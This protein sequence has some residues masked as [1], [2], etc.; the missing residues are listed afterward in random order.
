MNGPDFD[1]HEL[2]PVIAQDD[3]SGDVLEDDWILAAALCAQLEEMEW[4]P[5]APP[6]IIPAPDPLKDMKGKF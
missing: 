6:L 3:A 4:Q 5:S 1:K 2:I